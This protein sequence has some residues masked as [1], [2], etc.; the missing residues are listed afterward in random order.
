MSIISNPSL[1][2]QHL[3]S[4]SDR[5]NFNNVVAHQASLGFSQDYS[6]EEKLARVKKKAIRVLYALLLTHP[7]PCQTL[8]LSEVLDTHRSTVSVHINELEAL[9]LTVRSVLEGTEKKLKPTGLYGL[10]PSVDHQEL[11]EIFNREFPGDPLLNA[12]SEVPRQ[13]TPVIAALGLD[14]KT[15]S[16]EADTVSS[17]GDLEEDSFEQQIAQVFHR[18]AEEIVALQG[19]VTD[20]EVQLSQKTRRGADLTETIS[21]LGSLKTQKTNH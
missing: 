3:A 4:Q 1:N 12:S 19:R 2:G 17:V 18:M 21:L 6:L 11:R 16:S 9:D 5:Q 14:A 7:E 13:E 15:N 20:L 8:G 10:H